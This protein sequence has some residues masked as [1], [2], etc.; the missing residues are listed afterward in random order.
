MLIKFF[1]IFTLICLTQ[2]CLIAS[3][4]KRSSDNKLSNSPPSF[5]GNVNYLI[6]INETINMQLDVIDPESDIISYAAVNFPSW[7]TLN[8][9][10]GQITGTPL[11]QDT[12]R[13]SD[14]RIEISDG[15]NVV[16]AGP[17]TIQVEKE[18]FSIKIIWTEV[19]Q[20]IN[21]NEIESIAGYKIFIK[22]SLIDNE[23]EV[24]VTGSSEVSH[25]IRRL[26]PGT[27]H[28]SVA[29]FLTSGLESERSSEEQIT[30]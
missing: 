23:Q 28:L 21:D 27:Y 18:L 22:D 20:D 17:Y 14:I 11:A 8:T 3:D 5:Q 2:S 9:D 6:E 24:I 4:E 1:S 26:A 7:L 29:S 19:T 13:Y 25:N 16:I 30:L 12:G 10:T 15:T